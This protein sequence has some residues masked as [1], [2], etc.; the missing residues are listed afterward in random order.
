MKIRYDAVSVT[1]RV[2][3][4]NEDMALVLGSFIRDDAQSS[5]VPMRSRPRFTA[6][7]ADG[8]GG[9]GGGEIASEMT[10][11]SFDAFLRELPAGMSPR[12]LTAAVKDWFATCH[13]AVT[14]RAASDPALD[15]MGTTLTGIF[16]YGD[17]EYMLNSGDS[18]VYR[19]RYESLRRLTTD[20]SERERTGDSSVPANLIY[21]A[22]GVPGA[23][24]EV[25]DL[26]ADMP[27]IDGDVYVICSDGLSDMIDDDAIAAILDSGGGAGRLVDAALEA[28]GRD[29]CTVIVL[30]VSI[31]AEEPQPAP[32]DTGDAADG[33]PEPTGGFVIDEPAPVCIDPDRQKSTGRM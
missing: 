9:Y 31:P 30:R 18:R 2:R 3:D 4:G 10:L 28:G 11:R 17:G 20:H 21:N 19:W 14:E 26:T 27:V 23:F 6:L 16:T 33:G 8:M 25:T 13:R 22:V 12:E 5:M 32:A 7:V 29:N 24:V 15:R 1:G